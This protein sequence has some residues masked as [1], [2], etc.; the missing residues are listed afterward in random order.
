MTR[1][2][3]SV[4]TLNFGDC[5]LNKSD[6]CV[7]FVVI[8]EAGILEAQALLLCESIRI[9][10]GAYSR[11][12]ITVVSPRSCRRPSLSMLRKLEELRAEYLPIEID[13]CCP[14][15]GTSY[16]VHSVA[17]IARRSGPQAIVQ[18]DSDTIFLSEPDFSLTESHAAARPVDVKGMCTTGPGDPFD[19]YWREL[20]G[21]VGVDYEQVS[22]VET[23][24]D[25]QAVRASYNGGLIAAQRDC[26]IFERTE[27]IFKRLVAAG[28][29]PWPANSPTLNTGT[30]V[31]GGAATAYWG[32]SQ[33]AF[34]LAA[35]AGNHSVRLLPATHNFPL[36]CLSQMTASIP[37]QLVHVHYHWLFSA[38]AGDANPILDGTLRLPAGTAEWL[39]ARLPLSP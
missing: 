3:R 8:A 10:A 15:Y 17:H 1:R 37:A 13:S 11:S 26:G 12:P 7:E 29:K 23:T 5:M 2:R 21:L 25:C 6:D 14:E 39:K 31:L 19:N 16:R 22:I 20:C 28:L 30:G 4:A 32:T 24:V 38:G 27:N 34:S 9:F 18:L 33:A 36:N 35:V